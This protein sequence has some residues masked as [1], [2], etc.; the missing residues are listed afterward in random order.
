[1]RLDGDF[2]PST[3]CC[4]GY[5]F[6]TLKQYKRGDM[7]ANAYKGKVDIKNVRPNFKP[8]FIQ[9]DH[10][11]LEIE[12]LDNGG[13]YD[14]SDVSKVEFTH[15]R[16]DNLT[17]IYPG[18][19]ITNGTK[20]IIRYKYRGSE[21][22]VIGFVETSFAIFDSDN[23][24]VSSHSFFVEIKKDLRDEPFEPANPSFGKLQTLIDDVEILKVNGGGGKSAYQIALD[25]GFVGT[26][27][28]WLLSLK[29]EPGTTGSDA[30]ITAHETSN[31]PH[32]YGG[33]VEIRYNSTTN[34]LD[35]VWLS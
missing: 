6:C 16:A 13:L 3:E 18:E 27:N 35:V 11:R 26:E 1:M 7:M 12:L 17:I 8:V 24:K 19:I 10:A 2:M 5:L 14:L 23:N 32:V 28:E 15:V 33:R 21:M 31:A 22:D 34:S 30:N 4:G 9:Y 29:G 20:K 25:N